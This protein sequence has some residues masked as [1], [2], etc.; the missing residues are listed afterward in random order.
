MIFLNENVKWYAI[1]FG[2]AIY[3]DYLKVPMTNNQS[4]HFLSNFSILSMFSEKN[5]L[6][7]YFIFEEKV[8]TLQIINGIFHGKT[9]SWKS[10]PNKLVFKFT[11]A[12]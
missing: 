10:K 9:S 12:I 8:A 1:T 7:F 3:F 5:H 6:F 2:N 4:C 11:R